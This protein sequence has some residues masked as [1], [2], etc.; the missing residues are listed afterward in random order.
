MRTLKFIVDGQSIKQNPS[1]DFSGL[2]PGTEGYLKA[3]FI[4]SADWN[5]TVKVAGFF[6]NMG[7]EYE[8]QILKDGKTCMIPAEALR[9]RIFKVQVIGKRGDYKILTN[10][11]TVSQNGGKA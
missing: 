4:F 7:K 1:C 8:P 6:S 10:K 5:D 3:E 9:N 11:V 2:V